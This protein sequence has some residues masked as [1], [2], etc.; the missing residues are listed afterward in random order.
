MDEIVER[1][2]NSFIYIYNKF[3]ILDKKEIIIK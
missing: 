3:D 2:E 1:V